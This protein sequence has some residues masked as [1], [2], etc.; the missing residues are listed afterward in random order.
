MG[1]TGTDDAVGKIN[2]IRPMTSKSFESTVIEID[3]VHLAEC[4][5][6]AIRGLGD[7]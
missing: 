7:A 5:T 1:S 3:L 4:S 6:D 2:P